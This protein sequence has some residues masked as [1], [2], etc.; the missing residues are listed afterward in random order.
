M[1]IK[2]EG[3]FIRKKIRGYYN[4]LTEK[5]TREGN[6]NSVRVP[7]IKKED[8]LE[9][10]FPIAIFQYGLGAYDMFLLTQE[11]LYLNKFKIC[12]E[13]AI[14]NQNTN[15]SWENFFYEYPDNPYSSM[16]QGEG[17]SL[18]LRAY[19][20]SNEEEFLNAAKKAL[21]FMLLP[22]EEGGTTEYI[23]DEVY[24]KEAT[25]KSVIL[26]GWIFSIFGLYDYLLVDN[27]KEIRKV[28][29]KTLNTLALK[30]NEF[31]IG[32]LS[33]YDNKDMLCSPFYH[34]LHIA[35]LEV[36]YDLT[37]I[38]VFKTYASKWKGYEENLFYKSKSFILK[39]F[40][41][42]IE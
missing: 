23:G 15:G 14:K 11:E 33:K 35:Q 9:I 3:K 7:L 40:Q 39:V 36:L 2:V 10:E 42:V 21:D 26:N 37:D 12:V 38:E 29:N 28:Y 8:G 27:Q 25:N 20:Q 17:I 32:Y 41:K 16:A 34:K 30:L 6:S 31:D 19:T 4:D 22:I 5:I 18:L 1:L 24:L 13:W